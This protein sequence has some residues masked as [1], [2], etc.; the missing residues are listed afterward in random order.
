MGHCDDHKEHQIGEELDSIETETARE[1]LLV[2]GL[3]RSMHFSAG[4]LALV[5]RVA[6]G[7]L[8][9]VAGLVVLTV[10]VERRRLLQII[11]RLRAAREGWPP[12]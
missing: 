7:T 3:R 9:A 2:S 10:V 12:P 1:R 6:L 11:G 5:V 4:I 8:M